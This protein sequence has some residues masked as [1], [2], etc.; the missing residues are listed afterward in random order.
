MHNREK[1]INK[2]I[3]NSYCSN[4]YNNHIT[5]TAC[6]NLQVYS[7]GCRGYGGCR[8]HSSHSGHQKKRSSDSISANK[9]NNINKFNSNNHNKDIYFNYNQI[10]HQNNKYSSF[11]LKN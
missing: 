5:T 1:P 2:A 6:K 4:N 9:A 8:S 10:S 7:Q 3:K 11:A